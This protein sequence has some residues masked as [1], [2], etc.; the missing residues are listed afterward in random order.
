MLIKIEDENQ[1]QK[2]V[3]NNSLLNTDRIA[4]SEYKNKIKLKQKVD[5]LSEEI[6]I[7]KSDISDIKTMLIQ[8]IN[9]KKT[10]N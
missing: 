5:G 10:E 4:L 6:N 3:L 9:S 2:N 7:M 8:L 1:F